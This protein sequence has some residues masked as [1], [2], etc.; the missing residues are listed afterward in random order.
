MNR[1]KDERPKDPAH[2]NAIKEIVST[3]R[4]SIP[5][6]V[7]A[8]ESLESYYFLS[9]ANGDVFQYSDIA[10]V[11]EETGKHEETMKTK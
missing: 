6:I 8:L 11:K 7:S 5:L 1:T 4:L 2:W 3:C 9:K 10:K